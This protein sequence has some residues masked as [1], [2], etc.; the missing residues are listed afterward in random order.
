MALRYFQPRIKDATNNE[1]HPELV[2][3]MNEEEE[4]G[5]DEEDGRNKTK[6]PKKAEK[7]G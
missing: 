1:E 3:I 2:P 4:D 5:K 7:P 6:D